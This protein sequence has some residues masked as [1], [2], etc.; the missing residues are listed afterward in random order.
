MTERPNTEL[1][2]QINNQKIIK[3]LR[4]FDD[5]IL[6]NKDLISKADALADPSSVDAT[7]EE[8]LI[9][10]CF[11]KPTVD[12]ASAEYQH[13]VNLIGVDKTI[14]NYVKLLQNYM[15]LYNLAV[16]ALY[17]KDGYISWHHNGDHMGYNVLFTYSTDGDGYFRYYDYKLKQV[18][19][20]PDKLGWSVKLNHFPNTLLSNEVCW[21]TAKT[22]NYRLT[23]GF[24]INENQI[25]SVKN[26]LLATD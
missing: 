7:S 22:K 10:H 2:E 16:A 25:E 26:L 18:V 14:T 19:N 8:Y 24:H 9:T 13:L 3:I 6:S 11:T 21:H 4:F 5:Y 20:I 17:P 23:F 1:V 15:G 12:F